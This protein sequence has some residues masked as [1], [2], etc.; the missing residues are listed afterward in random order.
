M[1]GI[2]LALALVAALP[3]P[4]NALTLDDAQQ[5]QADAIVEKYAKQ[6]AAIYKKYLTLPRGIGAGI[7]QIDTA[8]SAAQTGNALYEKMIVQRDAELEKL[9]TKEQKT[10][11]AKLRKDGLPLGHDLYRSFP[12]DGQTSDSGGAPPEHFWFEHMRVTGVVFIVSNLGTK[13]CKHAIIV[14]YGYDK[15]GVRVDAGYAT[16]DDLPPGQKQK[17]SVKVNAPAK[18]EVKLKDN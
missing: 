2:A 5:K 13:T 16:I 17:V 6:E 14:V 1:L 3:E 4:F 12:L 7:E 11:L 15:D 9:L 8:I 10:D 18:I